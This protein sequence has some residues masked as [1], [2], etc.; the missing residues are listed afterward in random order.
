MPTWC[1]QFSDN[2]DVMLEHF[3]YLLEVII[4]H[5]ISLRLGL[6]HYKKKKPPNQPLA[7]PSGFRPTPNGPTRVKPSFPP[8]KK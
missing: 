7:D 6:Q 8:D 2:I 5:G 4:L 3:F 1:L